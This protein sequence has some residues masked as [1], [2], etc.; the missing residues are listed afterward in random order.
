MLLL[1]VPTILSIPLISKLLSLGSVSAP[2]P[3]LILAALLAVVAWAAFQ[4][5]GHLEGAFGQAILGS[6]GLRRTRP[7]RI[8]RRRSRPLRDV[9]TLDP[10]EP[11][12]PYESFDD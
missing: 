3:I 4:I 5:Q 8:E 7:T 1:A 2:V 10:T 9:E 11:T 6:Q 12:T